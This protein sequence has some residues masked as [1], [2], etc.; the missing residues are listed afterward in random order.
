[1]NPLEVGR[2]QNVDLIAGQSR[3]AST[4]VSSLFDESAP[5]EVSGERIPNVTT[6][7]SLC[8]FIHGTRGSTAVQATTTV[9][10]ESARVCTAQ[11]NVYTPS[12][13]RS[14]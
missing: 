7:I 5:F 14:A 2:W 4:V 11:G 8:L 6:S 9:V 1:M 10:S 12:Q 3:P 13:K